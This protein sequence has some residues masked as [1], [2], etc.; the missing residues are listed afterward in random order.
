MASQVEQQRMRTPTLDLLG[1]NPAHVLPFRPD[2][3]QGY[4][5]P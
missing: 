4:E 2:C 5:Q 1:P 3:P